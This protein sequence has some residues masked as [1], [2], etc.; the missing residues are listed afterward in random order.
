MPSTLCQRPPNGISLRSRDLG[1]LAEAA[2]VGRGCTGPTHLPSGISREALPGDHSWPLMQD[3]AEVLAVAAPPQGTQTHS[4]GP[5]T[6]GWGGACPTASSPGSTT[7]VPGQAPAP[8]PHLEG[9]QA[10][11]LPLHP[12]PRSDPLGPPQLGTISPADPPHTHSTEQSSS[13]MPLCGNQC[14]G[15]QPPRRG[16]TGP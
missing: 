10:A 16:D 5:T 12:R 9:P 8:G 14:R 7:R 13:L 6:P 1:V 15:S 2:G 4:L 11:I 3:R